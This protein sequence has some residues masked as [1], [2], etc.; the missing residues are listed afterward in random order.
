MHNTLARTHTE[1]TFGKKKEKKCSV[2]YLTSDAISYS[3]K[4]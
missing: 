3:D 2:K 4:T 1:V